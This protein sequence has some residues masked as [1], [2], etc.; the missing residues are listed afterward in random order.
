MYP[1]ARRMFVVSCL[2]LI[3]SA[4][5]FQMRQNVADDV[6]SAT[7]KGTKKALLKGSKTLKKAAKAI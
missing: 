2:A 3:T 1:N 5:S 7:R 6:A 4:F